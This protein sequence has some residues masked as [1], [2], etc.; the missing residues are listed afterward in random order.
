MRIRTRNSGILGVPFGR[1]SQNVLT[2]A[3]ETDGKHRR[4][5]PG[6]TRFKCDAKLPRSRCGVAVGVH[7]TGSVCR[8]LLTDYRIR[9]HFQSIILKTM[10]FSRFPSMSFKSE[11]VIFQFLENQSLQVKRTRY[12]PEKSEQCWNT[13]EGLRVTAIPQG[14]PPPR[15]VRP[16][17][18]CHLRLFFL[19]L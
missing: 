5:R 8:R 17:R 14:S 12:L 4:L 7:C 6:M 10:V 1:Q 11:K 15:Q 9:L 18:T 13:S 3:L 19:G 16:H 2:A